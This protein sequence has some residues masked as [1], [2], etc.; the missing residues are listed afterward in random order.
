MSSS[1]PTSNPQRL[2]EGKFG[3]LLRD[4]NREFAADLDQPAAFRRVDR[5]LSAPRK[6]LLARRAFWLAPAAVV[7]I[8][9]LIIARLGQMTDAPLVVAEDVRGYLPRASISSSASPPAL[10]VSALESE[11][12]QPGPRSALPRSKRQTDVPGPLPVTRA[13]PTAATIPAPSAGEA[14]L[15]TVPGVA[16]EPPAAVG[17]P[18]PAIGQDCLSLARRGQTRDAENCFLK[19]AEGSGLGA[20][21][22]LYEVARMRRDVLADAEGALRALAEYRARFPSGALRREADMSQLELLLQLGRSE[23]ALKQSAELLSSSSSGERAA[24]LHVLRGHI[25]RKTQSKFAAA[26]LEYELAEKA[27]ARGAELKYFRALCLEALGRDAEA[28]LLFA[29]Y[30]EQPRRAY[31]EDAR[32]RLER[33]KP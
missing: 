2:I 19:R 27:G 32:R 3:R 30:V 31:A 22:A 24:E 25:L 12:A 1:E 10:A 8:A 21:M 14:A 16:G 29:E 11:R 6:L 17:E 7:A 20:E 15:T 4:A 26:A 5:R 28:A 33:L 13:L 9:G 23:D 18:E